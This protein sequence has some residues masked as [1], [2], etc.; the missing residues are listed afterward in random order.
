MRFDV[1]GVNVSPRTEHDNVFVAAC[2]REMSLLVD[3]SDIG[4]YYSDAE[5]MQVPADSGIE[6][7]SAGDQQ[8]HAPTARVNDGQADTLQRPRGTQACP[9]Q[10]TGEGSRSDNRPDEMLMNEI[11]ELWR[12][13]TTVIPSSS[14]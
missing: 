11:E 12:H 14:S 13:G 8:S 10:R 2:D 3:P 9:K 1:L 5:A 7:G 4:L 6:R